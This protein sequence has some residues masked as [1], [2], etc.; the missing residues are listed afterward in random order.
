MSAVDEMA[1]A[2]LHAAT[3]DPGR[4]QVLARQTIVRARS[5]NNWAAES[6]ALRAMGVARLQLR[7]LAGSAASLRA[8]VSAAK[9][10]G[11]ARLASEAGMSL[12]ATLC[13]RGL[14]GPAVLVIE[15]ALNS[16]LDA[17][18]AARARVQRA[19][20]FLHL[21]RL[22]D[23]IGDV[24][25]A[26][27]LLRGAH[28][29][30]WEVQALSNRSL[31]LIA[32][33]TFGSAEHDLLT[34]L[35]ICVDNDLEL[36]TAYVE[37][38]LGWLN[39]S[40]GEV[41]AALEHFEL[42]EKAFSRIGLQVGS[43]FADR[44]ELLLSV[45]L[46]DE[47]RAAAESAVSV[48][49]TQ[50]RHAQVPEAQLLLS[51]VALVQADYAVASAAAE[52]ALRGY[53]RIG[54]RD[55]MALARFAKLQAQLSVAPVQPARARRY[56]D[57]LLAAG[58]PVPALEA[59]V[60]AGMLALDRGQIGA[61]KADLALASRARRTGPADVR[62]RAWL[63]EALLRRAQ[64][65]RSGAKAAV[66]AGLRVVEQF[67]A[68]LGA[69]ELR[70][71]VST[72]RGAL[73]A[74]GLRMAIEDGQA[75]RVLSF[76]ERG[77][78]SALM[79]RMARPP[80]DPDISR[81]L[82]DLRTTSVEIAER[83]RDGRSAVELLARQLRLER[84]VAERSRLVPASAGV[85]GPPVSVERLAP[86]LGPTGLVEYIELDG[87]LYA[88]SVVV[89]RA[90][91]HLLGP[92]APLRKWL[93]HMSFA[94][95]RLADG[96][97]PG[98]GR[99]A[100]RQVLSGVGAQLDEL[101][102]HPLAS[103]IGDRELVV[104]PTGAVQSLPWSLLPSLAGRPLSVSPSAGLWM[105]AAGSARSPVPGRVAVV[106]GP[107][108]A[109]AVE[110]V[111][112]VASLYDRPLRLT[113]AAAT[114][115]AVTGAMDGAE[116]AHIAAHGHLR[117][118]NP[119]F[120]SLSMV[121]GPLTVHDL[122]RLGRAPRQVVLAACDAAVSHLPAAD[123][124]LG[125][126]T[127]LLSQGTTSLIAPV[128]PVDDAETVAIMVRYHRELSSGRSPSESLAKAQTE[129]GP[130]GSVGWAAAAS[131]VCL[132]AGGDARVSVSSGSASTDGKRAESMIPKQL[133]RGVSALAQAGL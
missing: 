90:E 110:E 69:T 47:A 84:A 3:S 114:V 85:G 23:A 98:V 11:S 2:A 102:L 111:R 113:G 88:V 83:Q 93:S 99:Q 63:A 28:D 92:S 67:S 65:R 21:G 17:V 25:D 16:D 68:T 119:L 124:M 44:A 39:S 127:A 52:L 49:R 118:D 22:D 100:A 54:R 94:L 117:A 120:S 91:L 46:L 71:H 19:G 38:N 31:A 1:A 115:D 12:S 13:V 126:A 8:A 45:R 61:A 73:A 106:A 78:A 81:D 14:L 26:L 56:A 57:E 51:T 121:D 4:S 72:H 74:L 109:G 87:L 41:V 131:F 112:A 24:R 125:L 104:V 82:A 75:A 35:Q 15:E 96:R 30:Q 29:A 70:A 86:V 133:T 10:A 7:D 123:E 80:A 20:I 76:V 101:L 128:S 105:R 50:H 107:G 79:P 43:L 5:E 89:G 40:R 95:R 9:R 116:L 129:A 122:E 59:R 132:G 108:L 33:R 64:G 58:W 37:H 55:G 32:K 130:H 62:V 53:R 77:R 36:H 60:L 48:H 18:A 66:S 6:I 27:P 42:A 97:S 103:S 34:A